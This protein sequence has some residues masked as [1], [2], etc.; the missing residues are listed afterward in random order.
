MR[1]RCLYPVLFCE[2]GW[3][4]SSKPLAAYAFCRKRNILGL[5]E[6]SLGLYSALGFGIRKFWGVGEPE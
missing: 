4:L 5:G 1:A 6:V 2:K 3:C